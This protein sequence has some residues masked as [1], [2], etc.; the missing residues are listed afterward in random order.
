MNHLGGQE[1][2]DAR[3]AKPYAEQCGEQCS[4]KLEKV[5]SEALG[6][7][8]AKP[9]IATIELQLHTAAFK[10]SQSHTCSSWSAAR[11]VQ[12]SCR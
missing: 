1:I 6:Q 7:G 12:V 11:S 10:S 3:P 4:D 8:V 5:T 2:H 9:S